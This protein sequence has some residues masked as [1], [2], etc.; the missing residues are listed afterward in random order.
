MF[1]PKARQKDLKV[2]YYLC[3]ST[4]VS[5]DSISEYTGVSGRTCK[6]IVRRTNETISILFQIDDF[7][8]INTNGLV[9]IN[10]NHI[11]KKFEIYFRIQLFWHE[12][13]PMSKLISLIVE[14]HNIS[15]EEA[16]KELYLSESSFNKLLPKLNHH[17]KPFSIIVSSTNGV[18][19]FEGNEVSVRNFLFKFLFYTYL[20]IK[21][22]FSNSFFKTINDENIIDNNNVIMTSQIRTRAYF[23]AKAIYIYRFSTHHFLHISLP[24]EIQ[25][26]SKILEK[27]NLNASSFFEEDALFSG[28]EEELPNSEKVVAELFFRNYVPEIDSESLQVEIGKQFLLVEGKLINL[29]QTLVEKLDIEFK[30]LLQSFK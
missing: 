13:S 9:Q 30:V 12:D 14:K 21:W 23:I 22:P 5:Y 19:S 27:T 2:L 15:R 10:P 28:L 8:L 11:Q 4:P 6:E 17:L 20:N 3:T 24:Q 1:I 25:Q 7:I 16:R 18:L 26:I 29:A